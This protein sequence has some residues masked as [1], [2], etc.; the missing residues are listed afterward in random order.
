MR[1]QAI[2]PVSSRRKHRGEKLCTLAQDLVQPRKEQRPILKPGLDPQIPPDYSSSRPPTG[3][4]N[5]HL[6]H[7]QVECNIPRLVR[8]L[9]PE[10]PTTV[11]RLATK[12]DF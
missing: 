10:P 3:E 9:G 6:Y 11:R 2:A 5:T 12:K 1:C 7:V 4:V 8:S